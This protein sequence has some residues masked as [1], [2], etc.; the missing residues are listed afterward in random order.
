MTWVTRERVTTGF[1]LHC[2]HTRKLSG[3]PFEEMECKQ[4][5]TKHYARQHVSGSE[6]LE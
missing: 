4:R 5:Y 2:R 3:D 1:R 6:P